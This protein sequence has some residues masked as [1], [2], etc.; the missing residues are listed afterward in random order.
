MP[1]RAPRTHLPYDN[2]GSRLVMFG[3]RRSEPLV[4]E[5]A[6]TPV[7]SCTVPTGEASTALTLASTHVTDT[8]AF[9]CGCTLSWSTPIGKTPVNSDVALRFCPWRTT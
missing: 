4:T 5:P 6:A 2:T 7:T 3:L 1:D 8:V 9:T